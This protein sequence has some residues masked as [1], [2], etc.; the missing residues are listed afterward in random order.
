M[1]K[2]RLIKRPN[3]LSRWVDITSLDT[4]LRVGLTSLGGAT[5]EQRAETNHCNLRRSIYGLRWPAA[6]GQKTRPSL[7]DLASN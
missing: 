6:R 5:D 4:T 2:P 7:K 1:P 3:T